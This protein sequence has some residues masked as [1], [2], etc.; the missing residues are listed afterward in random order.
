MVWVGPQFHPWNL[1]PPLDSVLGSLDARSEP[2][3]LG[4]I[5]ELVSA[6]MSS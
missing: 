3:A 5:P 2:L 6:K 1:H 4:I